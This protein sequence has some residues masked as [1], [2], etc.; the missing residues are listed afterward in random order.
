MFSEKPTVTVNTV[1]GI[2][3]RVQ[4]NCS[5]TGNPPPV[6]S[7]QQEES[8][9]NFVSS[10][11]ESGQWMLRTNTL[12]LQRSAET[13]NQRYRCVAKNTLG[14]SQRIESLRKYTCHIID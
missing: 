14:Q 11:G 12:V 2:D 9:S 5:A 13:S 7:W 4:L 10:P 6:V 8:E 3:D 1:F